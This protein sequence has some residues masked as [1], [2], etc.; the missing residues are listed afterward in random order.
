MSERTFAVV[1]LFDSAQALVDA[2][3]KVRAQTRGTL[4]AYTPYPVH[5][6]DEALQLPPSPLGKIVLAMGLLGCASALLMEWW[7]S[8]VNYPLRIGGKAFFSWQA[9]IP[10]VF[11]VTVLFAAFTSGLGMLHL[12]N[13][14]PYFGHPLLKSKAIAAITRDKFALSVEAGAESFDVEAAKRALASAG[15]GA[16]EVLTL[17]DSPAGD[18]LLAPRKLL[19]FGLAC[20]V[21]GYGT[22]WGIKLFPTLPP[23][24]RASVQPKLNPE[25]PDSFF[26][27]G[28]GMRMPV[29][30]TVARGYLPLAVATPEEAGE[31]LADPLPVRQDVLMRGKAQYETHCQVCHGALGDGQAL[32]SKAYGAK[33][34]NLQ[35][36]TILDYKDGQI[37]YV[38]TSGK[39][40]MPAYGADISPDD[41]W[42]IVR[43]VR[44]LQ[45][46]QH[47]KEGDLP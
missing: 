18:P 32:L 28:R 39:N 46:S 4:Q 36:Q 30:G 25:Q 1:A 22:Y 14:L 19:A 26:K 35:S 5:G 33:P 17:D 40:S 6:L 44:A 12:L 29:A 2:V 24:N 9:F 47:A 43:Y 20:A 23:M 27:D 3:P 13:R 37:F 45:R 41:R 15:G 21:A 8:A 11:E 38:I 10:V 7:M 31:V 42:A 16:I 34:A